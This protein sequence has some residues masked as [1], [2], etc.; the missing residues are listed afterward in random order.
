VE[1]L[2]LIPDKEGYIYFMW[3]ELNEPG[4]TFHFII[5]KVCHLLFA[6]TLLER[7]E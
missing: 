2:G 4:Y 7:L 3:D 1:K 5:V 6:K